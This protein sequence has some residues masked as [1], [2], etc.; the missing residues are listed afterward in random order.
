MQKTG[1]A[2]VMRQGELTFDTTL[3]QWF[4]NGKNLSGG[5]HALLA[6]IRLEAA[7]AKFLILDESTA[8]L[9]QTRADL[10][11]ERLKGIED[12]T[13]VII[14]HDLDVASQ[15][16]TSLPFR[17]SLIANYDCNLVILYVKITR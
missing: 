14:S 12:T 11:L 7:D 5:H 3:G 8:R 1:I 6:L 17:K 4:K 15:A 16:N 13:R 9:H 2:D 10:L